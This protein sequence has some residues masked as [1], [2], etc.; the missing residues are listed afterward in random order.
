MSNF[1]PEKV[2]SALRILVE[3]SRMWE[4]G[5]YLS[6]RLWGGGLAVGVVL[7]IL[8]AQNGI[9]FRTEPAIPE[10][11]AE[12]QPGTPQSSATLVNFQPLSD[13]EQTA[14]ADVIPLQPTVTPIALLTKGT[15]REARGFTSMT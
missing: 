3:K 4:K 15:V 7:L 13:A 8:L 12:L 9:I 10:S 6:P 5:G 11:S 2:K 1:S 14:M